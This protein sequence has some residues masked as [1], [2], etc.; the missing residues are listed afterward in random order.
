MGTESSSLCYAKI[1]GLDI[2]PYKRYRK[3]MIH[4]LR[5]ISN[6]KR[7]KSDMKIGL[8]VYVIIL[9]TCKKS[10]VYTS[11]LSYTWSLNLLF[12]GCGCLI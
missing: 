9:S 11:R 8:D 10:C 6:I 7:I 1:L 2:N 3:N 4:D 5:K 12:E